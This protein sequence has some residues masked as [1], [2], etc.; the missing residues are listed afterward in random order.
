MYAYDFFFVVVRFCP[1]TNTEQRYYN[2]IGLLTYVKLDPIRKS[3]WKVK[4]I[5]K[6]IKKKISYSTV[7]V[8]NQ[9]V[10]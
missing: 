9:K 5:I 3:I 1:H 10:V 7:E 4:L 6:K 8:K 2:L